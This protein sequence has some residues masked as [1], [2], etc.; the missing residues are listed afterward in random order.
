MSVTVLVQM[1]VECR[2]QQSEMLSRHTSVHRLVLSNGSEALLA[3]VELFNY[4]ETV[5]YS[6]D[7]KTF[8]L[9][10]EFDNVYRR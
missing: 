3:Y 2:H 8:L 10:N 5:L 9:L 4:I 6:I 1:L 7:P